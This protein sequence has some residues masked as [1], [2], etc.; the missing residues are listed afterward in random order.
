MELFLHNYFYFVTFDKVELRTGLNNML[1]DV[2]HTHWLSL[3]QAIESPLKSSGS[4]IFTCSLI[5]K[6]GLILKKEKRDSPW[7]EYGPTD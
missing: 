1:A 2:F 7:G 6:A 4:S 3:K 5:P